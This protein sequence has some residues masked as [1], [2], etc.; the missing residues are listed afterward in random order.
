MDALRQSLPNA[1]SPK[2][3]ELM[4]TDSVRHDEDGLDEVQR[5]TN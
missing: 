3:Y 4:K 1:Q 5:S 2:V